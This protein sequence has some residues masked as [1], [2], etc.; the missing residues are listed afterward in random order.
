MCVRELHPVQKQ[1]LKALFSYR[2]YFLSP[3]SYTVF[4]IL[5]HFIGYTSLYCNK[6]TVWLPTLGDGPSYTVACVYLID[7]AL[8]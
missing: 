5:G 4:K 6:G 8:N 2:V 1:K 3:Y 7:L